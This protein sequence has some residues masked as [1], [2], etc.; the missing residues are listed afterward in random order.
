MEDWKVIGREK[1]PGIPA[2]TGQYRVGCVDLMHRL[3][4]D[5][6][7]GLLVR[8]HYPTEVP[9]GAAGYSYS[10]WYPHR[11]YI[12]GYM[13]SESR[14]VTVKEEVITKVISKSKL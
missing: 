12:Q 14:D 3:A 1:G 5:D 9:S 7:G 6:K 8:L 11:R 2:P 4:G 10:S 13:E